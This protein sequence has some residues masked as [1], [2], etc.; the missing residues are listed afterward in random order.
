VILQTWLFTRLGAEN[1]LEVFCWILIGDRN[2]RMTT[3]RAEAN[4]DENHGGDDDMTDD[5]AHPE[6]EQEGRE[7]TSSRA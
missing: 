2:G 3:L 6:E 5:E 1:A 4:G 7:S